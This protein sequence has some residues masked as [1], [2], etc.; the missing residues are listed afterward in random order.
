[1]L[2]VLIS[3]APGFKL[4]IIVLSLLGLLCGCSGSG[5]KDSK[6]S[7][8]RDSSE[9]R[10]NEEKGSAL[11]PGLSKPFKEFTVSGDD[12]TSVVYETGTEIKVPANAFLDKEGK[13]VKGAVQ[14]FYREW[15]SPVEIMLSGIPMNYD[16]AGNGMSF[17][18]AGMCEIKA[19]QNNK[20]LFV[21]PQN[22]IS[23][24]MVSTSADPKFNRYVLDTAQRKWKYEDKNFAVKQ[25]IEDEFT[26]LPK[27]PEEPKVAKESSFQIED[28]GGKQPELAE[29]KNVYFEP[30]NQQAVYNRSATSISVKGGRLAGTYK[31]TVKVEYMGKVLSEESFECYLAF[32]KGEDYDNALS[33][34]KKK[35]GGLLKRRQARREL[36]A[37]KWNAYANALKAYNTAMQKFY[38]A[39]MSPE[40][41][42][43][44]VFS[45]NQFATFNCDHPVIFPKGAV[46]Q[47]D[48]M[49]RDGK[50]IDMTSAY[51]LEKGTPVLFQF[52]DLKMIHFNPASNN[53]LCGIT[54]DRKLAYFSAADFKQVKVTGGLYHF[55]MNISS[56]LKSRED[57]ESLLIN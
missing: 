29:Y 14:L 24:A 23:I 54:S 16:S 12:S 42:I 35:Y 18:T 55:R 47:A 7:G 50:K 4:P 34:Y 28:V 22:K 57:I 5:T 17:E 41:R 53:V 30:V 6:K 48:F 43:Q 25:T 21:N 10:T 44:N 2:K 37:E 8:D 31:V 33:I 1:M 27:A 46:V 26:T 40:Q 13:V 39:R 11:I 36:I 38:W 49:D 32:K 3:P 56:D 20:P 19:T 9:V 51:L 52:Y 15:H 45:I